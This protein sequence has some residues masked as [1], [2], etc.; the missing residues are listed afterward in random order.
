MKALSAQKEHRHADARELQQD[1]QSY[2]EGTRDRERRRSQALL[3]VGDGKKQ[4]AS[5][6]ELEKT[7]ERLKREAQA[8]AEAILPNDPVEKKKPLWSMEDEVGNL[9][10]ESARL[11]SRARATL[12]AA[13]QTDPTCEEARKALADL[14]WDRFEEAE[15]RR[16]AHGVVLYR[17]LV[18]AYDS[19]QY[20]ARLKGDGFLSLATDP[21]GAEVLLYRCVEKDRILAASEE[22]PLGST[23]LSPIP[24]PMG[25]YLAVLKLDGYRD[26]RYPVSIGRSENRAGRVKLYREEEIGA[27]FVHVPGGEFIRGGDPESFGGFERSKVHAGDFFIARFPV[28]MGEYCEFLDDLAARGESVKEH[29]PW[30][31][32]EVYVEQGPGG[33]YRPAELMVVGET[34]KRYPPG[35]EKGC[36]VFSVSWHSAMA[37]ARWRSARDS[38][39]YALPTE[40]AWEK[41]ARGVDG[42]F[43]A[44]GDRFDW[45]FAKGGLS[46]AERAQPEPVGIFAA[47]ESPYGVRDMVGTIREWTQSWFDERAGT[48]VVRGGSWNLVGARHFR[49]ANRLGYLSTTGSSTVGF[50]LFAWKPA[51]KGS[52]TPRATNLGLTTS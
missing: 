31:G 21:P 2:I 48:R 27:E 23:P 46:R 18:E 41:A 28:T 3:L 51:F 9:E 34:R 44:W 25:S 5:Y 52:R 8:A 50:R 15:A 17:G 12:D 4:I 47:D 6:L 26:T 36:P 37:Y 43:H 20:A 14:Y 39:E 7:R 29:I 40:D 33:K 1:L 49:C 38:R 13:I 22:R 32:G 30:Q 35:F 16:D 45:N 11:F 24:L 19:G 10:E 42:R